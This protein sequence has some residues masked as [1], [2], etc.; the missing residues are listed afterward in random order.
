VLNTDHTATLTKSYLR[1]TIT[2]L[3]SDKLDEVCSA[4]AR[5]TGC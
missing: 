4:F 3:G 1:E 2:T 5:A